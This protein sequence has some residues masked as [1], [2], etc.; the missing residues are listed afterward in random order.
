MHAIGK[1]SD[2]ERVWGFQSSQQAQ[3]NLAVIKRAGGED[4]VAIKDYS[5]QQHCV[6]AWSSWKECLSWEDIAS[7]SATTA[8]A[9]G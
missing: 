4:R 5:K 7:W 9:E 3:E 1:Q 2:W 8:G 6:I